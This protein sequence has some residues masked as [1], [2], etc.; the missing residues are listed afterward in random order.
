MT[1]GI[2]IKGHYT[3]YNMF[4][5]LC[6]L[7]LCGMLHFIIGMLNVVMLIVSTMSDIMPSVIILCV[8]MLNVRMLS[9]MATHESVSKHDDV[10]QCVSEGSIKT[11]CDFVRVNDP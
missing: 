10:F 9:V 6:R 5:L 7:S 3:E 8:V 1:L 4:L 2:S 11:R